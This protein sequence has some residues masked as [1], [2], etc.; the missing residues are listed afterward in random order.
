MAKLVDA[1][2]LGSS[3]ARR[4][5]SSP[6]IRT[7]KSKPGPLVGKVDSI[8]GYTVTHF[9]DGASFPVIRF[10]SAT[11]KR[12]HTDNFDSNRKSIFITQR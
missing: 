9:N 7:K 3:A 1:L 6:T 8:F 5:G 12:L 2:D 4:V 10:L 11:G